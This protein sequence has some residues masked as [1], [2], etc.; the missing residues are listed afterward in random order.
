MLLAF[1]RGVNAQREKA[2]ATTPP[3]GRLLVI[4]PAW[5]ESTC[6]GPVV[7]RTRRA[8]P[9]ATVLVVDDG[10]D[11]ATEREALAA[12]AIVA[13][14]PYNLGIGGAVQTGL[15]YAA[16]HAYDLAVQVDGDGQH[17]PEGI[18]RLID[19]LD[20]TGADVVIGSRFLGEGDYK[21]SLARRLGIRLFAGVLSALCGQSLTD[22]TSGFRC[23]NRTAIEHLAEVYACDY[24]EVESIISLHKAGFRI[25][26]TPVRMAPRAGGVS[27]IN[28]LRA[29]YYT[30]KV[31]LAVLVDAVAA[32]RHSR[33]AILKRR[34]AGGVTP[35]PAD[36]DPDGSEA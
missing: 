18:P 3:Q 17:P 31:L 6:V 14:L 13:R 15:R 16:R 28:P 24:P 1:G 26:E 34:A 22:T 32:P 29:A 23:A 5:N 21:A 19:A 11:D 9:G 25:A 20:R 8:L 36:P 4:I 10:S 2:V 33:A 35:R 27:S 30:V 7:A 12:G